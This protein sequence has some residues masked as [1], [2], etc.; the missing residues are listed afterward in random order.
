M[1][2]IDPKQLLADF[3]A[4]RLDGDIYRLRDFHLADLKGDKKYGCPSRSFDCDDTNL[5]RAIYCLAFGEVFPALN[6]ETLADWT[7]RGDTVNTYNTL[8]GAPDENSLHPGLDRYAPSP[9]LAAK[10][11]AFYRT[12]HTIGNLMPLP[13]IFVGR[14]TFNLFRGTHPQWRDFVDRFIAALH[15]I[16]TGNR[17][18]ADENLCALVDANMEP[19]APYCTTDGFKQLMHGL[20]LEDYL[21]YEGKPIVQSKGLYFW[22]KANTREEYLAEV[23]RFI[24]F[25]N[26]IISRRA[27]RIIEKLKTQL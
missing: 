21:D 13:N 14:R 20:M 24:D 1:P 27:N 17:A 4:E 18:G 11:D 6:W 26:T 10:A 15:P 7:F 2:T 9:E 8:L 12:Y 23:E 19:L 5:S 25:S 16:L 3:I 22:R